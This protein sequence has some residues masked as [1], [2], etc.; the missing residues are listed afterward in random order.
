MKILQINTSV[1]TGSTGRIAEDIGKV[2]IANG[3]DSYIA[4]GRSSN[5]SVSKI[6]KIGNN[7]DVYLHGL[8]TVVFDRHGFG[9]LNATKKLIEQIE[10]IKP[11]AI[12][13]HNLHG[14]YLN[15]EL[16]MKFLTHKEIPILWTL[17]DCW[18]FTG[19]C[20]Y[21]DN[22]N[23]QKWKSHCNNCPKK[24]YYPSSYVFDNSFRNFAD[25]KLLFTPPENLHLVV[26]SKWLKNLIKE[27]FLKDKVTHLIHSGIDLEVFKPTTSN[28]KA[29]FNL[30][31]K[32][33]ILGCAS[34]WDRRKGFNDFLLLRRILEANFII[35]LIGLKKNV[36]KNL[37]EGIL[38][39]ER[40]ESI[41][42]LAEWYSLADVFMNPTYMDNFPTTNLEAL[43]C[44]T[45]VITY[46]TGGSP[47]AID[48]NTGI[49]LPKGD[50]QG[51]KMGIENLLS[52]DQNELKSACRA[53]AEKRFDKNDRFKDYLNIYQS[54]LN[55]E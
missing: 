44:G 3:H 52:R 6:I 40:T 37:P 4:Y 33:I 54:L 12:G 50:I 20:S 11:D 21:F 47:E 46:N 7:L 17:F 49:V 39:F 34:I 55:N 51:I 16:L 45:P 8:K 24:R 26:H 10:I 43:A 13:L 31:G 19:H 35:I 23:C 29:R 41:K 38:G 15:I 1:N 32:K 27:S 48:E 18:A 53:R 30:V 28:L 14:Y 5:S 2:L 25:K 36:I 9:S 22:I 42:E